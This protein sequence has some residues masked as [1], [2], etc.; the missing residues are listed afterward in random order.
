MSNLIDSEI[1]ILQKRLVELEEMNTKLVENQK[2]ITKKSLAELQA[3]KKKFNE[4]AQNP[5]INYEQFFPNEYDYARMQSIHDHFDEMPYDEFISWNAECIQKQTKEEAV[6]LDGLCAR[7]SR[8]RIK[9]MDMESCSP[10]VAEGFYFDQH[11]RLIIYN[12][13]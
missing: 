6:W 7:L 13:R 11:A 3:M 8:H 4:E 9:T 2:N 10:F 5:E 1:V 12:P